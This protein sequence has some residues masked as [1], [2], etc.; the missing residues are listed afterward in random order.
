M[1]TPLSLSSRAPALIR[2]A[3]AT[4]MLVAAGG[5]VRA[6]VGASLVP[7][8]V[9]LG[10]AVLAAAWSPPAGVG[11]VLLALPSMFDLE[12]MPRGSFSLLE[13]AILVAAS[14]TAVHL[15][16][17]VMREGWQPLRE[18][19]LPAEVLVPVAGLVVATVVALLSL[20]DPAHRAESL[21]EVRLVIVEPLIFL[22]TTLVVCR[23]RAARAWAAAMFVTAG[24]VVSGLA[25]WQ[26]ISG[27]GGVDAGAVTRATVSYP[28]PNNLAFFL[29]RTLLFTGGALVLRPRSLPLWTLCAVQAMGVAAT[30]SRGAVLGVVAGLALVLLIL[31]MR[32]ALLLLAGATAAVAAAA[33]AVAPDRVGDVGG[34]GAEPTRFAIWRS[35]MRM[36]ADHPMLGVGPDQFLYQY[37]RRYVEPMGWPERY[38]SHPHNL[39]LDAWLRLGVPG[40]AA[41]VTLALGLVRLVRQRLPRLRHDAIALGAVGALFGGAMHGM[42]DNGFFLPDLAAMTWYFVTCVVTAEARACGTEDGEP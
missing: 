23:D 21:R 19:R 20:A 7:A 18:V 29:E 24:T 10:A 41:L 30:F 26:V 38:T 11:A 35:S 37:W 17:R 5:L 34:A 15:L 2:P 13:L 28:H 39:V 14:G 12:P 16:L 4:L 40:L 27:T 22:G 6:G 31:R 32:R 25:I 33:L 42:V 1:I 8:V 3:I 9:I 36:I